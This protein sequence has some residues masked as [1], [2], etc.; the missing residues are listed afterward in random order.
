MF[1]TSGTT[2]YPAMAAGQQCPSR[3]QRMSSG[4]A[5]CSAQ[6]MCG[7]SA[8]ADATANILLIVSSFLLF[9]LAALVGF[10]RL[11]GLLSL[12]CLTRLELSLVGL[13][14][15]LSPGTNAGD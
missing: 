10:L 14:K 8:T 15:G 3:A 2:V 9:S 4:S 13:I 12:S 5:R 6:T 11:I 7:M 1:A